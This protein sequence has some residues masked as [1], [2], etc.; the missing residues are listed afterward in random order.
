MRGRSVG[1]WTGTA[2]SAVLLGALAAPGLVVA[3]APTY[4]FAQLSPTPAT[5]NYS[6]LVILKGTYTCLNGP[7]PGSNCPTTTQSS[8]GTFSVRPSGGSTFTTVATVSSSFVFASTS[9]GCPT[10]CSR[11]FQVQWKAGKV[12]SLPVPPGTYDVRLTTTLASGEDVLTSALVITAEGTTTTYTG[13]VSGDEGTTLALNVSVLD[14]DRGLSAG[15]GIFSPDVNLASFTAVT[16]A[17]YDATNTTL[18]AGPVSAPVTMSGG[19]SGSPTLTLPAAGTYRLR[20]EYLGNAFYNGS[21]DLDTVISNPVN[22]PPALAVPGPMT[23]EATSSAGAAVD[24]QVSAT[25]VEDDP[26]PTPA[27][28]P[29]SGSTFPL[30]TTTV[31]CSVTDSGGLADSGSFDVTVVDTT[32]PV[33]SVSTAESAGSSGWYNAASNDGVAGVTV[34]VAAADLVGVASLAC[35]DDGSPVPGLGLA[36][37]S[38][39][40]GDGSHAVSCTATDGTGNSADATATFD[41]DQTAPTAVTF[42]GGGLVDGGVYVFGSVPAG[43]TSC[44][45]DFDISG[46]GGCVV[47]GYSSLVGNR[48]VRATATDLAGNVATAELHY[49]VGPWT[50]VGFAKPVDMTGPNSD[51]AGHQVR[52]KFEVW[53]GSTELTTTDVVTGFTETRVSCSS[54]AALAAPRPATTRTDLRFGPSGSFLLTWLTPS[55]PRTCWVATVT[56]FDGSSLSAAFSL[57]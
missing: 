53:A 54:G 56:T 17:L 31:E 9:A 42:A 21:S 12:G 51:K 37:G 15:T 10:T 52:L 23:A 6:D 24:Y 4:G 16:F 45:A 18:M 32:A 3:A 13:A 40:L 22:T 2:L 50:L 19:V 26:D 7:D 47:S 44:S 27:C 20:T 38:F 43:P 5:V 46:D 41:V 48:V 30:G 33:V 39:V 29:P 14:A 1:R 55:E 28:D 35:T 36:G 25:D 11:P 49:A 8:V 34:D 57:R